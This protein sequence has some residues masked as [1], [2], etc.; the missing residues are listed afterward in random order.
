[1]EEKM[2]KEEEYIVRF[3]PD[4][5]DKFSAVIEESKYSNAVNP[6]MAFID[7]HIK[8]PFIAIA[9]E[10]EGECCLEIGPFG[11]AKEAYR[12]A[13]IQKTIYAKMNKWLTLRMSGYIVSLIEG[14]IKEEEK[15]LIEGE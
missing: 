14:E 1:M 12:F 15:E 4:T 7:L 6:P 11:S 2:K 13:V 8:K 3:V 5:E 10:H 9:V